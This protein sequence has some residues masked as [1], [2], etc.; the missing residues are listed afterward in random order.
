MIQL[1]KKTFLKLI[2]ILKLNKND[3]LLKSEEKQDKLYFLGSGEL[4]LQKKIGTEKQSQNLFHSAKKIVFSQKNLIFLNKGIFGAIGEILEIQIP[5][6]TLKV[7]SDQAVIYC[8][9]LNDYHNLSQDLKTLLIK[10][11]LT[12][13]QLY[14]ISE[15][16]FYDF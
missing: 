2:S 5:E 4:I 8:L 3:F 10:E 14:D 11:I 9:S 13:K 12:M 7:V 6:H 1:Y 15:E 16:M